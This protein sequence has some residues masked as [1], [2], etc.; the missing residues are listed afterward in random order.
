MKSRVVQGI[1]IGRVSEVR[2]PD[3]NGFMHLLPGSDE[4]H[5]AD[6][7]LAEAAHCIS[8]CSDCGAQSGAIAA[9]CCA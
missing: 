7:A 3:S 2:V 9:G 1:S 6:A 4:L 8:L 5:D